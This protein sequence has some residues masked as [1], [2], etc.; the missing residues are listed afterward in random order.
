MRIAVVTSNYPYPARP[1]C[2]AFVRELVWEFARQGHCCTVVAPVSIWDRHRFGP[3]GLRREKEKVER[4]EATIDVRRPRIVTASARPLGPLNSIVMSDYM[5]YRA[6]R[7]ELA[8]LAGGADVVY[9]HFLYPGGHAAARCAPEM[10]L[11]Y[12][13]A[14][15]D[16]EIYDWYLGKG[17]RHFKDVAGVV[18]VST[19]L[20]S[21]CRDALG[22]D[23]DKIAVF[24]NGTDP[25]LFFPR[26]RTEARNRLGL[27]ATAKIVA[28]VGRFDEGKGPDRVMAA[29]EGL[30]DAY[31]LLMGEGPIV[32]QGKRVA[33]KGV[34]GRDLLP[35]YLSAADVFVLPTTGEGSC[36]AILE[37]M[38]CGLPI[39]SSVG[40]FND[41][42]LNPKVSVRVDP[43]DVG[44]IREAIDTLLRDD[45]R[46][47]RMS[48]E[49]R[50]WSRRFSIEERA[51]NIVQ[52]IGERL[53]TVRLPG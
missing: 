41:D 4:A 33:F 22:I 17:R 50:E 43:M 21:F 35:W 51:R 16:Y 7:S 27:S 8:S 29:V 37:A 40:A 19:E 24:P 13:V 45:A 42:I 49:C 23:A 38:A 1:Y 20:A 25:R 11:P 47:R 18:A 3:L 9:G 30:E 44:Q 14:H 46:R 52:F 5:F 28:F 53:S 2:G 15:G 12:F 36:N 39:V 10:R 31:A 26:D 32:I 6:V 34:V 48:E